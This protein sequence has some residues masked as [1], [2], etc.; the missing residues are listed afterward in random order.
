[1]LHT[2]SPR[3]MGLYV[4]CWYAPSRWQLWARSTCEV[5]PRL[6]TTM[7]CES[8]YVHAPILIPISS[9]YG[10]TAGDTSRRTLFITSTNLAP[11]S[12]CGSS[13]TNLY[14][15][16][17]ANWI[18]YSGHCYGTANRQVGGESSRRHGRS[19]HV[20]LSLSPSTS[21]MR[22]TASAGSAPARL[23]S[24]AVS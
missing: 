23:L 9:Q 12:L 17:T 4:G 11:T 7:I 3:A 13:L 2:Q 16:T 5:I 19:A 15:H 14:L 6:C 20:P 24:R 21:S 22:R 10:Q 8:Q 1:M 18:S